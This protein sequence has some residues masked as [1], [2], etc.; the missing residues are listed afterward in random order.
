MQESLEVAYDRFHINSDSDGCVS[1]GT[2][3]RMDEDSDQ[4]LPQR[5]GSALSVGSSSTLIISRSNSSNSVANGPPGL[6]SLPSIASSRHAARKRSRRRRSQQQNMLHSS[7]LNSPSHLGQ[8]FG[9]PRSGSSPDSDTPSDDDQ[10]PSHLDGSGSGSLADTELPSDD[11]HQP[12]RSSSNASFAASN[13]SFASSIEAESH[14]A[15]NQGISD[16][17][18]TLREAHSSAPRALFRNLKPVSLSSLY[19]VSLRANDDMVC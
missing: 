14:A 1:D 15:V 8:V 7:Y 5:S 10:H 13:A 4:L 11:E 2:D 17:L 12:I 19:I 3:N 18:A 16:F 9:F 6:G